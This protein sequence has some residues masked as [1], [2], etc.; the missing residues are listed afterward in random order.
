MTTVPVTTVPVTTV[1]VTT[2]PPDTEPPVVTIP[3]FDWLETDDPGCWTP[4]VEVVDESDTSLTFLYEWSDC[5]ADKFQTQKGYRYER[6][7]GSVN[8]GLGEPKFTSGTSKFVVISDPQDVYGYQ[9]I[10]LRVRPV[11]P[12]ELAD[13]GAEPGEWSEA[14][15]V[16]AEI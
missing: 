3:D 13:L 5:G 4:W 15:C 6:H 11:P 10:C 16:E 8:E 9:E 14:I 12:P 1:P 7:D 2:V